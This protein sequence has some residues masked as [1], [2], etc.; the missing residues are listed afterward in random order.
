[1]PPDVVWPPYMTPERLVAMAAHGIKRPSQVKGLLADARAR[2]GF[3]S[4]VEMSDE[5]MDGLH[6]WLVAAGLDPAQTVPGGAIQRDFDD[7]GPTR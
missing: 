2:A 7:G 4:L 3:A 5:E 6:A 1:M